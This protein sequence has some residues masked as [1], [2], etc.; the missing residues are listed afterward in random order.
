MTNESVAF[1]VSVFN[2]FFRPSGSTAPYLHF[3]LLGE[4]KKDR[5]PDQ[6]WPDEY[7][8]SE[9]RKPTAK[10]KSKHISDPRKRLTSR[11]GF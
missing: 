2:L 7:V 8:E 10:R 6:R 1:I 5:M 3:C 11:A 4:I 9:S